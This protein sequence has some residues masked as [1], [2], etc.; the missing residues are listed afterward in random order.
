MFSSPSKLLCVLVSF[1]P[2]QGRAGAF[3]PYV[4]SQAVVKAALAALRKEASTDTVLQAKDIVEVALRDL[5]AKALD[6]EAAALCLDNL[7]VCVAAGRGR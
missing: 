6:E 4:V 5:D 1:C 7:E 2:L 3:P